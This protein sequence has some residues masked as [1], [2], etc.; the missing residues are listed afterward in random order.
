MYMS[1]GYSM[2]DTLGD[3]LLVDCNVSEKG[4]ELNWILQ[5]RRAVIRLL[6]SDGNIALVSNK[7][8]ID[9]PA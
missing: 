6:V 1:S 2:E 5:R 4:C 3:I 7:W 9:W 8:C